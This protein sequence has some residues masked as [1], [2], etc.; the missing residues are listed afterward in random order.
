[1]VSLGLMKHS[2]TGPRRGRAVLQIGGAATAGPIRAAGE[3]GTMSKT[4]NS[5]RE[6]H[7][8]PRCRAEIRG[9]LNK[10]KNKVSL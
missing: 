5:E 7:R 2:E 3:S 6:Q 9:R 10:G 1:M 4:H 8:T